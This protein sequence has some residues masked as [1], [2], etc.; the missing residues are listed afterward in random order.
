[1]S[2]RTCDLQLQVLAI[3]AALLEVCMNARHR[4]T[5]EAIFADPVGGSI[6]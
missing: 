5:L 1:M 4:K 6:K 3:C 2:R